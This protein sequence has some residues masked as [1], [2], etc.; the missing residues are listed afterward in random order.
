MRDLFV[1]L[2]VAERSHVKA[3]AHTHTHTLAAPQH[4]EAAGL[5]RQAGG[6]GGSAHFLAIFG[7]EA[8]KAHDIFS[9]RRI[10]WRLSRLR[11]ARHETAFPCSIIMPVLAF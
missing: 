8:R 3:R 4:R 6:L 7:R 11:V 2:T 9:C 1:P 10:A 5:S